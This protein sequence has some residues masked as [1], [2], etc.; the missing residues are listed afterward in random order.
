VADIN[1]ITSQTSH[2]LP[3]SV[4][5]GVVV[6]VKGGDAQKGAIE[7]WVFGSAPFLTAMIEVDD[8]EIDEDDREFLT[9]WAEAL[10]VSLSVLVLRIL[11]A[12]IDGDQYI[13][14]RPRYED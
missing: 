3:G 13:K 5:S 12:A 1:G 11:E 14:K 6:V 9:R 10:D 2:N 4:R 7:T 8:S